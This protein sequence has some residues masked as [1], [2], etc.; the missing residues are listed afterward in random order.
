MRNGLGM[1]RMVRKGDFC[2]RL[3]K[4]TPCVGYENSQGSPLK[5]FN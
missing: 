5:Q 4:G 3:K 1:E 2:A